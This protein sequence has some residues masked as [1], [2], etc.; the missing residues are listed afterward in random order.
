MFVVTV[1]VGAIITLHMA[2]NAYAGVLSGNARMANVVF[3]IAGLA[4][5]LVAASTRQDPDFVKRAY[6]VPAWLGLAGVIGASIS[7]FTNLAI[8]RIGASNLTMLLLAGQLAASAALSHYGVLGSPA[9][10]V[11]WRRLAGLALVAAGAAL[12]IYGGKGISR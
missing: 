7:L 1:L 2:M 9:E 3:W 11:S 6:S 12:S 8:P 10:P 4:T 5:A